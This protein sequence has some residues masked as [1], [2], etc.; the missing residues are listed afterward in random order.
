MDDRKVESARQ[1]HEVSS[2]SYAGVEVSH[3][4]A[5]DL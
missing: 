5:D 3:A 2:S 4:I 1:R